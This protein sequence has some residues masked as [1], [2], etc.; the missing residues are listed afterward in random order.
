MV[1]RWESTFTF[2]HAVQ[3]YNVTVTPDPSTCSNSSVL[4]SE[5]YNCPELD[6]MRTS[7]FI[8]VTA[9]SCQDQEGDRVTFEIQP[10]QLGIYII[11]G[12][13]YGY[14]AFLVVSSVHI[15]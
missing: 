12:S 6:L 9:I 4:P 15:S 13:N 11:I 14:S 2:Q 5:E 8:T 3:R 10:Q 7:Y 1:L